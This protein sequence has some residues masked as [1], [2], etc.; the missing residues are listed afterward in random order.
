MDSPKIGGTTRARKRKV[1]RHFDYEAEDESMDL[2]PETRYKVYF[3]FKIVDTTVVALSDGFHQMKSHGGIFEL[4]YDI[5]KVKDM[6]PNDLADKCLKLCDALTFNGS[7]DISNAELKD[8]LKVLSTIIKPNSSPKE[9]LKMLNEFGHGIAPNVSVAL[10]ILLT[11]PVAN[12]ERSFSKL[13]LIKT[14]LRSTMSQER[15]SGLAIISIEHKIVESLDLQ[16][17]VKEFASVKARR[18]LLN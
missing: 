13:K 1:R 4:L 2:D 14:Y 18:V 17:L 5:T 9:T 12:G 10:R 8:E 11:L 7:K 3:H 16:E 15:L 6:P